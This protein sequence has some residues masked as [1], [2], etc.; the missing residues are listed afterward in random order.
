VVLTP[1]VIA[2]R[3]RSLD[4]PSVLALG[5]TVA[6]LSL[7]LPYFVE[8]LVIRKLRTSTYAS[9]PGCRQRRGQRWPSATVV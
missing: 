4:Q 3:P 1:L 7:A 6:L 5:V 9:T 8:L 2:T